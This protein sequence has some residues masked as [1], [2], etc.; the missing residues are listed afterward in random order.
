MSDLL[1][2]RTHEGGAALEAALA[3]YRGLR[4]LDLAVAMDERSG[5][6]AVPAGVAKVSLSDAAAAAAGLP[7]LPK[8]T[9]RC[10]DYALYLVRRALAGYDRYWMIE[11]DVRINAGSA[12]DFFD[13]YAAAEQDFLATEVGPRQ[14]GWSHHRTMARFRP[15]VHG[16]L[17][18]LVRLSGAALDHLQ[19]RRAALYPEWQAAN[20]AGPRLRWPNDESFVATEL[21]HAGFAMADLNDFGRRVHGAGWGFRYPVH[22]RAALFETPDG[23]IYHPVEATTAGFT[24]RLRRSIAEMRRTGGPSARAIARS[25]ATLPLERGRPADIDRRP[26]AEAALEVLL[27]AS[28]E[29]D[30]A[31]MA[32][33][34]ARTLFPAGG[35]GIVHHAVLAAARPGFRTSLPGDF[36]LGPPIEAACLAAEPATAY[37]ADFARRELHFACLPRDRDLLE[38]PFFYLAQRRAASSVARVPFDLLDSLY[39]LEA[40][41]TLRPLVVMSIGRCGSTLLNR[42]LGADGLTAISEPDTFSQGPGLTGQLPAQ[43]NRAPAAVREDA[44]RVLRATVHSLA[45]WAGSA[46]G[47]LVL[48][49]R[50]QANAAVEPIRAAL[51]QARYLFVFREVGPWVRSYVTT[52][53]RTPAELVAALRRGIL[54][55]DALQRGGEAPRII[56]YEDMARDPEGA[57]RHIKGL[58]GPLPLELGAAI[59]RIGARDSQAGTTLSQSARRSRDTDTEKRVA[60][61]LARFDVLWQEKRPADAIARLGLPY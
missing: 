45:A 19:A 18:P 16:C 59:A 14:A 51:P 52:F 33:Q 24:R 49:L 47:D 17:F 40:A 29:P 61:T 20:E 53:E 46:P 4:G 8:W 38:D 12:Q 34:E 26:E 10:G 56:W 7:V 2:L 13:L 37:A 6:V 1:V 36:T 54:A 43:A 42:L 28:R 22:A 57:I 32:E 11:P 31:E 44:V 23:M 9:Y 27:A 55:C 39:P 35:P 50:A 41:D 58:T 25:L 5:P 3:P 30:L 60:E 15:E 48:K 21:A